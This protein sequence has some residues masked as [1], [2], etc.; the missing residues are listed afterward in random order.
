MYICS[1]ISPR[2][3][4]RIG[5]ILI[6]TCGSLP[7]MAQGEWQRERAAGERT[8]SCS[9]AQGRRTTC[10]ADTRNG[11][12]LVRELP[13]ARCVEGYSWGYTEQGVWVD[14][15]CRAQFTAMERQPGRELE[16]MTRLE[17]GTVLPI[18][19]NEYITTERADGRIFTGTVDQDV[20]G[21]NGRLAVPR[22][23]TVE[24]IVRAARDGDLILDLESINVYGHRYAIDAAADRVEARPGEPNRRTG[25]AAGGGAVLG[26]IIGAIAGGG[27]GA[28]IGAGAGAAAG[29]TGEIL[30][31]GRRVRIPAES[32]LTFRLERPI[33]MD[34]ADQGTS[35]DGVHY[36]PYPIQ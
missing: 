33:V 27:K 11:I 8:F 36:H 1:L 20:V 14:R 32:L 31:R 25:E 23:S 34:A 24:L 3:L 30:T 10:E 28:A 13:G 5:L 26:A 29:A 21:E 35:R 19:T 22:G 12:R 4:A 16:R 7:V 2:R 15:G 17:A 18:R 6:G 9:S